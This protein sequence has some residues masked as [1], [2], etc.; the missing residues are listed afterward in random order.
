M[1][2]IA[3]YLALG[4]CLAIAGGL[5]LR[6]WSRDPIARDR[7]WLA[8]ACTVA[9]VVL[10]A[11][12][13]GFPAH[14]RIPEPIVY[15]FVAL[16]LGMVVYRV[17]GPRADRRQGR[18]A[19][20]MSRLSV[21]GEL[22]ASIAHEI[23]QPLGAI[24]SNTDA[25]E[26]L[27]ES[28]DP[29]L[30][31]VRQILKDI[32]R[33]GLRASDVIRHVRALAQKRELTFE[34]LDANALAT[35]VVALVEPDLRR[36]RIPVELALQTQPAYMRGDRVYM[37]QVLLNL[38]VNAMDA[39]EAVDRGEGILAPAPPIVLGVS[40]TDHGEVQFRVVDSGQGIPH[41]HLHR[42]FD[43]FYTSKP[44]GMG[45]GL[46]IARSIVEAHG[47]WIRGE[48]NRGSGA[49]FRVTLPPFEVPEESRHWLDRHGRRRSAPTE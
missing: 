9:A 44:H 17:F 42:L 45:L 6:E 4:I 15:A 37:Q 7:P 1:G 49:T 21:V 12:G 22:T 31:E 20:H 13:L 40:W 46:S 35:D 14:W 30:E 11:N 23:N 8:L 3:I 2:M 18:E 28:D 10:I 43:S 47:G 34:K 41:D 38:I 24:L 16:L 19:A 5:E 25:A 39:V 48:N 27:L 29:P 36:R 33:D 32:R 26:I